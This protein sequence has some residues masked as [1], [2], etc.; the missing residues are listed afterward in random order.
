MTKYVERASAMG[1]LV[2]TLL[3]M[4][5]MGCESPLEPSPLEPSLS[6][7]PPPRGAADV[8]QDVTPTSDVTS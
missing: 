7:T 5:V 1:L 4:L 6:E 3:P 8:T 2:G